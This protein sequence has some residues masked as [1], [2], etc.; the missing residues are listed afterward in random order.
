VSFPDLPTAFIAYCRQWY[1]FDG[2]YLN[3]I[4][5]AGKIESRWVRPIATEYKVNR[6]IVRDVAEVGQNEN[7]SCRFARVLNESHVDW[8]AGLGEQAEKCIEIAETWH[9]GRI[10]HGLQLA[11]ATKFMW[12]LKPRHWTV[13][14]RFAARGL[15]MKGTSSR[16]RMRKFYK[17]LELRGFRDACDSISEILDRFELKAIP[18]TRVIDMLLMMQGDKN[19]CQR[20]NENA[21]GFKRSLPRTML[22]QIND[23]SEKLSEVGPKLVYRLLS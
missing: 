5:S 4:T 10:V 18:S 9:N 20:A 7:N 22:A 19:F 6:G 2:P 8:P 14:D 1:G 21:E 16:D 11:A 15:G 17:V 12:F 3:L 13:Y 23:A